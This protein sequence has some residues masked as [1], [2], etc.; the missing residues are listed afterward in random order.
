MNVLSYGSTHYT[1]TTGCEKEA[2]SNKG[3]TQ[4]RRFGAEANTAANQLNSQTITGPNQTAKGFP[5]GMRKYTALQ[6]IPRCTAEVA[7]M[8]RPCI[9]L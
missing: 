1:R 3:E 5:P 6:Y 2:I 8:L 4:V 9:E 7:A